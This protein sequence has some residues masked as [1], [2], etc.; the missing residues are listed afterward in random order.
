MCL[1]CFLYEDDK[2]WKMQVINN[3]INKNNTK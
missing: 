2:K 1:K 3:I